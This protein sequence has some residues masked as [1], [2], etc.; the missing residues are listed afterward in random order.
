MKRAFTLLLVALIAACGGSNGGTTQSTDTS[1]PVQDVGESTPVST[2]TTTTVAEASGSAS[3]GEWAVVIVANVDTVT[4]DGTL[5]QLAAA[6][7]DQFVKEGSA[8]AGFDVYMAGFA[9][10]DEGQAALDDVRA[11]MSSPSVGLVVPATSIP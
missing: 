5:D 2:A 7:F 6:G 10:Q 1:A 11:A 4:A 3:A 9:T 8:A